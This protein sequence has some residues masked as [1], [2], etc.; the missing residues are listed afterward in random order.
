MTSYDLRLD[1]APSREKERFR[2]LS[3]SVELG[4]DC[5]A[6]NVKTHGK[7]TANSGGALKS[8]PEIA[9]DAVQMR[10]SLKL[11]ALVLSQEQGSESKG[12]QKRKGFATKA[13][14]Q[15]SRL[16]VALDE[17]IDAQ[18]LTLGNEV[19]RKFDIIAATPGNAKVFAFLCNT[20]EVDLI[21]LDFTHK[22]PFALNKKH[23]DAAVSRGLSFEISYAGMLS[24]QAAVRRE[25]ITGTKGLVQYLNGKNIVVSSGADACMQLRGPMDAANVAHVLGL[26][27][28]DA[29]QGCRAN[30]VRVMKRAFS[31]KLRYLPVEVVSENE[32]LSRWPESSYVDLSA[33]EWERGGGAKAAS[34]EYKD[35]EDGGEDDESGVEIEQN[36]REKRSLAHQ[37]SE[38]EDNQASKKRKTSGDDDDDFIKF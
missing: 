18:T 26:S 38:A 23:I 12:A 4:W 3:R 9:L 10:E 21:A 36:P 25:V 13:V 19:L 22:L 8:F 28:R 24:T 15:M 1:A 20:A 16:T 17:V 33:E 34:K 7:V 31:R 27:H 35:E 37:T 2:M 11:R 32:F 14:R 6:W 29:L 30:A 5:V